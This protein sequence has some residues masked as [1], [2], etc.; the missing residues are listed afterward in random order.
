MALSVA[1]SAPNNLLILTIGSVTGVRFG[2][3][4]VFSTNVIWPT[5]TSLEPLPNVANR[6]TA[7][8]SANFGNSKSTPRSKRCDA[9]V[10]KP[11][12]RALPAI[13]NCLKNALS[14]TTR[15]VL[16]VTAVRSPPMIPAN[17]MTPCS[18]AITSSSPCKVMV[19]SF[20]SSRVSPCWAWRTIIAPTNLSASNACSGWPSS[21]ST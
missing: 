2:S 5:L 16:S 15:V 6:L 12:R 3:S 20:K 7:R 17:A 18:S 1:I 9:S 21:S 19:C 4:A 13:A 11:K 10:C 14:I 8:S